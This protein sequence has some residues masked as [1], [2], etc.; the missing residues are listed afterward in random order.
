MAK[1]GLAREGVKLIHLS[2]FSHGFR[3]SP[4]AEK[5]LNPH[6]VYGENLY[7]RERLVIGPSNEVAPLRALRS[8]LK[9][10]Q[11][12]S[13]T[14]GIDAKKSCEST[15]LERKIDSSGGTTRS[16]TVDRRFDFA[17]VCFA[18]RQRRV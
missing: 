5:H 13:I 11:I 8:R 2:R 16:C 6:W 10:N 9:D 18:A 4:I 17:S 7:L 14:F 3:I 15:F 1:I 12:V